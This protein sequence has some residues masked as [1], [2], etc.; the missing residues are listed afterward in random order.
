MK[1]VKVSGTNIPAIEYDSIEECLWDT[2]FESNMYLRNYKKTRNRYDGQFTFVF[3][4]SPSVIILIRCLKDFIQY[5]ILK[6]SRGKL[7]RDTGRD[8]IFIGKKIV[9]AMD[10]IDNIE[11]RKNLT[12][13]TFNKIVN[14][15]SNAYKYRK[16]IEHCDCSNIYDLISQLLLDKN[17]R[18]YNCIKRV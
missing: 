1:L 10:L 12:K 13:N 9:K 6:F 11:Q 3:K 18:Q 14:L 16:N 4:Q 17:V 2:S 7:L 8:E 5:E 15:L